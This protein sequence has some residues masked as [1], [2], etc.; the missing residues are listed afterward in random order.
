MPFYEYQCRACGAQTE[1]LQKITDAALKKCASC[2]KNQ[3]TKLISA[4]VFRLKGSGW[5]ETDFKSDSDNKRNLA[6]PDT[7]APASTSSDEAKPAAAA[8]AA[9]AKD[10]ESSAAK[11][12]PAKTPAKTAAKGKTKSKAKPAAKSAA[13]PKSKARK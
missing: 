7:D 6:G 4:P 13:K 10:S 11:S 5:Y 8:A 3:L 1:V 9:P 2:G 12:S